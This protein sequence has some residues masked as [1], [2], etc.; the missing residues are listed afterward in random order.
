MKP[1]KL[2]K[3]LKK[4]LQCDQHPGRYSSLKNSPYIVWGKPFKQC[5]LKLIDRSLTS[6]TRTQQL[7]VKTLHNLLI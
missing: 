4:V 6:I 1:D 7:A 2:R 5:A 3:P